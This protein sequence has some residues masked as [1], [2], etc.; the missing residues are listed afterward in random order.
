MNSKLNSTASANTNDV[1]NFMSGHFQTREL[2]PN[3]LIS[4][5][6]CRSILDHGLDPLQKDLR[7]ML[8]STEVHDQIIDLED[9]YDIAKAGAQNLAQ[10]LTGAGYA[11][12][13][14]NN[15]GVTILTSC[16]PSNKKHGIILASLK[17]PFGK[18]LSLVQVRYQQYF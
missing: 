5:S 2:K 10:Q 3:N 8:T 15:Q 14:T 17:A 7:T 1:I 16:H 11:V 4:N 12:I 9:F 6:W 18:S 13:L